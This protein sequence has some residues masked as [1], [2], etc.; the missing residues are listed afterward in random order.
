MDKRLS[1]DNQSHKSIVDRGQNHNQEKGYNQVYRDDGNNS[2]DG[3]N[4]VS[5]QRM[6]N[7]KNMVEMMGRTANRLEHISQS[8]LYYRV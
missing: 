1:K 6:K 2:E 8:E 4:G 5:R 3:E 7:E